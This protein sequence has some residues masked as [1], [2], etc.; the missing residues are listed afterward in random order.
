MPGVIGTSLPIKNNTGTV[1][2][3]IK[4]TGVDDPVDHDYME[5]PKIDL[6]VP[7]ENPILP[8]NPEELIGGTEPIYKTIT[9]TFEEPF[10]E[11]TINKPQ[12]IEKLK[13]TA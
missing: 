11:P 10:I 8:Q 13:E 7:P 6:D 5:E 9:K 12:T 1:E 2:E 3:N 4:I